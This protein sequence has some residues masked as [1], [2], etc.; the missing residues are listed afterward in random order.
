MS[1]I[2]PRRA[3][4]LGMD[5]PISRRDFFDGV[6]VAAGA[7]AVGAVTGIPLFH[8][9]RDT[10]RPEEP[11]Y[12]PA[13]T[14]LRGDDPDALSVPHALRDGRFWEHAGAP[15]PTGESY[16]L[17][18]VGAGVSGVAAAHE[19]LRRDPG[20][21]VL[22]LDNHDEIGGHARR[23]EF[24]GGARPGPLIGPGGS[25]SLGPPEAWTPE[26]KELLALLGVEP[27]ALAG[28]TDRELYPGLGLR[29][30]VMCDREAF[31]RDR[32]VRFEPGVEAAEWVSRLPIAE[33]ARRDLVMLCTDPPDWFPGMSGEEKEQRL[34]ELTY[35]AFLLD[36]CGVHPDVERFCRT[37]PSARWGY[38][39]DSFGAIDAW[40][41]A[42]RWDYPGFDGLGLDRDKPS[43][44]NSP[45]VRKEWDAGAPV[46]FPEGNQALVR[47]L[48]GR[49]IPGFAG[50]TSADGVT[51][52]AYDY[53]RLDRPGSRVRL[54]LSS[55]VVSVRNDGDGSA[56]TVGY[57]DGYRLRT[58]SAGSVVLACW[59][60]VI[61]YL[62]PELPGD[63]RRALRAAVK[64]PVL[65]ATVRLRD[66]RAWHR[67]GLRAVRWTGA[68]WCQT[69]LGR[70]VSAPGY[71]CPRDPSEPILAHLVAAP[72]RSELGPVRGAAAGRQALLKTPYE[73]LEYT[74]RDQLTRLLEPHGFD[75][76]TGIEAVTVNRWGHG[77]ATEYRRP[78]H[79]FYPDG[80]FPA[81]AARRPFGRIAIANA[82]A[83]PGGGFDSAVTAAYR[84]VDDLTR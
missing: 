3:R 14:G 37:M 84:A 78:W 28:H 11:P 4:D 22:V 9:G 25:P 41:T 35:S 34:A 77:Y 67:A 68:Y 74:L 17:V 76:A 16:D 83:A 63:Q 23:N 13:L 45:T 71:P 55:P 48:V 19:W 73:N 8:G 27:D 30:G 53:G 69:E 12:P 58:V 6:A 21:R 52:A 5:R 32:L 46:R 49:M 80:P 38:G 50:S 64:T 36:V 40:G 26:G 33:Q 29:K 15:H 20:A 65:H 2:D 79:D 51:T 43:R 47:M 57:F 59:H 44:F 31:G 60:T 72:S 70:P 61:P 56:A 81:E 7:A 75:P 66:W 42:R 82:D 10:G 62:A 39:S 54:R 24:R 18:V 1:D